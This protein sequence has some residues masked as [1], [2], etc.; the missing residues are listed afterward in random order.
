MYIFVHLPKTGGTS[1]RI[2][3]AVSLGW[4]KLLYDYGRTEKLTSSLIRKWVYEKKDV[5]GLV[6]EATAQGHRAIC[7]HFRIARYLDALPDARY[8]TWMREPSARV[9]SAYRHYCRNDGYSG[10]LEEFF[11]TPEHQNVQ[12]RFMGED[13]SH[14]DFIGVTERYTE[15]ISRLSSQLGFE[16]PERRTDLLPIG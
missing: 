3:L 2:S 4:D 5:Q 12:S 7:G 10:S 14:F 16:L 15:S 8:I 1:L 11:T 9:W 13:L 6:D